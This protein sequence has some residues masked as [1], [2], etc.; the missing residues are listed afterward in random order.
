MRVSLRGGAFL[1]ALVGALPLLA[2]RTFTQTAPSDAAEVRLQLAD[3]MFA[4]GRFP[5]A[6][7][8]YNAAKSTEDTRLRRRALSGAVTAALRLAE[9]T[10]AAEDADMLIELSPRNADA[11]ALQGDT[12]W[13]LG[14]FPQSEQRFDDALALNPESARAL[15]GRARSL[16]SRSQLDEALNDA[17]SALRLSPRD[18]EIHYTVGAIYERL[19]RYE[20]AVNAYGNYVNLLP[21]KDRSAKADW[22][23]A[24]INFLRNFQNKPPMS[25]DAE[26]EERVHVVPF[27]IVN[28]KVV[29][30]AR[31]NHGPLMDF[32]LDTG[33]ERTVITQD[34]ARRLN[35]RPLSVTLSAGVGDIMVRGLQLGRLDSLTIGS[36][37]IENVPVL[38]KNPPLR[39][40]PT[41]EAEGFSPLSLGFS[42]VIDYGRQELLIARAL[43]E[44]G[45][46][47]HE[48]PL[49]VHRL[50]MVQGIVDGGP[51]NFVVD[52]GGEVISISADTANGLERTDS[53]RHIPLK[54]YGTSGWD[55][56]A[57]LLPGVDLSF[58][59]I[60]YSNFP[61]VVLNLRAPSVLLGFQLGGIVG[62]KFLSPYRVAIDL[63]ASKVRLKSLPRGARIPPN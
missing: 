40:L 49:R 22:S 55:R 4:E 29:L 32:T 17:Q 25:I 27:R 31:I 36:L 46:A 2:A 47:D 13:A 54:V 23:R 37:E 24:E 56:D 57:F 44:E 26:D 42:M 14:R 7:E 59:G 9:F 1:V 51:A 58:Q 63:K 48:L 39:N 12:L 53:T 35:I 8:A 20:E 28:D 15:H 16:A 6:L 33:S 43:P 60:Q 61:V 11:V 52:T 41:R 30:R 19:R 21:N 34:T 18:A 45:P 62:H 50:A 3:L 38:I 5:D 10:D